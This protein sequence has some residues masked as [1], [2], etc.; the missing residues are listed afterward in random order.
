[1]KMTQ[2]TV[3]IGVVSF[4]GAGCG[5][6]AK[7]ERKATAQERLELE[8]QARREAAVANKAITE[9]TEKAFRRRT[10]EEE[11]KHKAAVAAQVQALQ[12]ARQEAE[13]KAAAASKP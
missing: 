10:P 5:P 3:L 11:A 4:V 2:L 12:K 7:T 13:A 1:M 6:S 9:M 8:E